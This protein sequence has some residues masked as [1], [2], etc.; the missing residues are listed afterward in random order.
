MLN[1][2]Y[3]VKKA[4]KQGQLRKE[5]KFKVYHETVEYNDLLTVDES[6]RGIFTITQPGQYIIHTTPSE[7]EF[8]VRFYYYFGNTL[9]P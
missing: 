9:R 4:L 5:Y 3:E 7:Y 8:D 1:I 6:Y 2:P